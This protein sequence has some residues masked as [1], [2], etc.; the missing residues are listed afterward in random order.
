MAE[1]LTYQLIEQNKTI[2]SSLDL[3]NEHLVQSNQNTLYLIG[4]IGICF[5][6]WLIYALL[7]SVMR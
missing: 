6:V 5:G 4:C 1:D 3:I 2:I 7:K